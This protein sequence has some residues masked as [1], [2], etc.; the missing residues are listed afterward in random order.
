MENE[1][2]KN[3]N[4]TNTNVVD[5]VWKLFSSVKLALALILVIGAVSLL[6]ALKPDL[7][8]FNSWFFLVLGTLLVIN[9]LVCSINRWPSIRHI[10]KGGQVK[11]GEKFFSAGNHMEITATGVSSRD[12]SSSLERILGKMGYRVRKE[13]EQD[14]VYIAAD[15]NRYLR[16]GTYVSHLSLILFVTAYLLG[17]TLGFRDSN[18]TVAEGSIRDVGHD[19]GLSLSLISFVDEYYP[20]GM[21]KDYRSQVILYENGREVEQAVIRVNYP[22][23]Y[24]GIRFYQSFFGPTVQLEIKIEDQELFNGGIALD[25]TSESGGIQRNVGILETEDGVMI[26]VFGSATGMADSMI[27]TGYLAVEVSQNGALLGLDLVEKGAPSN[28]GGLEILYSEDKAF[29]GFQVSN[30]PANALVWIASILF[31]L[32]L[33][34]V[35]YFPYQQ[36]WATAVPQKAGNSRIFVRAGAGNAPTGKNIVDRINQE[37]AQELKK[38]KIT[39]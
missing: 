32:G 3:S 36:V 6:G 27:P 19:T 22:L 18:F 24:K 12:S 15:K 37:L 4:Q 20:D 26:R 35:F 2:N 23:S 28:I 9:I 17:G 11:Q 10:L 7:D 13:M 5:L 8:L 34:M 38:K 31:I 16:L 1:E 25:Q 30:D 14:R 39:K 29:S 33:V 21:P